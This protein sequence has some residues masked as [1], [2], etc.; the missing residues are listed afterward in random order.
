MTWNGIVMIWMTD[1]MKTGDGPTSYAV[2]IAFVHGGRRVSGYDFDLV[3]CSSGP[4]L[5]ILGGARSPEADSPLAQILQASAAADLCLLP[6][7][8]PQI[9]AA[10]AAS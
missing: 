2:E 3:S 9:V 1:L 5:K 4:L 8:T 10:V 6:P 7:S